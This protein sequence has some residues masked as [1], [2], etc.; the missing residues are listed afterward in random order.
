MLPAPSSNCNVVM[1]NIVERIP[2]VSSLL[3]SR[4]PWWE[5]KTKILVKYMW[6]YQNSYWN[7]LIKLSFQHFQRWKDMFLETMQ[8]RCEFTFSKRLI[9]SFNHL[10]VMSIKTTLFVKK[11]FKNTKNYF[12]F[13]FFFVSYISGNVKNGC[14]IK[15]QR[16]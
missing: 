8:C 6:T 4:P 15:T 11:N 16:F 5:T 10:T 14:N 3:I 7:L 2:S 12:S 13:F 9:L 1:K